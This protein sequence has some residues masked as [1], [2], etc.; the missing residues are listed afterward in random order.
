[1]PSLADSPLAQRVRK[2]EKK[3]QL[4]ARIVQAGLYRR[5]ATKM[6]VA[7]RIA[8][9]LLP[10]V[11][12]FVAGSMGLMPATYAVSLGILVSVAGT[13]AP[14][15]WLDYVKRSRQM[16]IRRALPDALDVIVVCLEGGLSLSGTLSRVARELVGAHPLLA[17]EL[18]IVEREIQMGRTT[19]QAMRRFADR[20]DLEELRSMASVISQAESFGSSVVKALGVYADTLRV[21]RHQFAEEMAQKASIK[22]L[23]PTLLL[24]FPGLFIVILGPAAI[25]IYEVIIKGH[26][27]G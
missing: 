7:V 21:R 23:F 19:G 2:Q 4:K 13:I 6:F 27:A 11:L 10:P 1:M 5:D 20:F 16:A 14:S 8:A 12:G 17:T 9:L 26:L 3:N 22:I 18:S 15:F 24:I 25:Q